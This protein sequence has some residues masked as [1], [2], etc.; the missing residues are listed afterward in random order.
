M[1]RFL[2]RLLGNADLQNHADSWQTQFTTASKLYASGRF[3]DAE[4]IA[5]LALSL[6]E[7]QM[8]PEHRSSGESA[9]LLAD[10]RRCRG[11]YAESVP[12]FQKAAKILTKAFGS[13]DGRVVITNQ[14]MAVAIQQKIKEDESC[15]AC[16]SPMERIVRVSNLC[17]TGDERLIWLHLCEKCKQHY[18]S[19]WVD[20]W[21]GDRTETVFRLFGPL[22]DEQAGRLRVAMDSCPAKDEKHCRCSVHQEIDDCISRLP[23]CKLA[24][25]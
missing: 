14:M 8:G 20:A 10:I 7:R 19:D 23:T 3:A 17:T 21:T 6:A 15:P 24:A 16:S 5:R 9:F 13:E 18:L 12:L 11:A 2:K 4:S 1:V 25:S 22:Q